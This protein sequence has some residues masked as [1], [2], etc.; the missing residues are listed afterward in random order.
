MM[1]KYIISPEQL[2]K[3]CAVLEQGHRIE[4]IPVKDHVKIIQEVR[5]EVK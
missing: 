5:K 3:I 2:E 4:L 1:S